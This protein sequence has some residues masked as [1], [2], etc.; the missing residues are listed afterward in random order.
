MKYGRRFKYY[1]QKCGLTQSEAACKIGIKGYQ[2]GNYE[3]DR[4]E[5]SLSILVKM[6]DLYNVSVDNLLGV[7][8]KY[9]I[10]V[11]TEI[12]NAYSKIDLDEFKSALDDFIKDF[13]NR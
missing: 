6:S 7:R 13:Q 2:L 10:N 8:K 11:D 4:S 1:R 3:T 5:P 12:D 9:N